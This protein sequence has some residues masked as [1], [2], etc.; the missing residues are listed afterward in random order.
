MI[1]PKPGKV[2]DRSAAAVAARKASKAQGNNNNDELESPVP[3]T[4][5][6]RGSAP[7]NNPGNMY[8]SDP[9]RSHSHSSKAVRRSRRFES[10]EHEV[11]HD[12]MEEF[13]APPPQVSV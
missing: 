10:S 2:R 9:A 4:P 8:K 13:K 7:R 1:K 6:S 11:E 5:M 3:D 12:H